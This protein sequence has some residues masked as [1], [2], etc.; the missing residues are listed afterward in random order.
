MGTQLGALTMIGKKMSLSVALLSLIPPQP[1][2]PQGLETVQ[3]LTTT[4]MKFLPMLPKWLLNRAMILRN[5]Q[6][7]RS[8]SPRTLDSSPSTAV[9]DTIRV[10]L[11]GSQPF[12]ALGRQCSVLETP[13]MSVQT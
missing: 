1:F 3:L 4:S 7:T 13:L 11:T 10:T 6:E 2:L 12:I 9:L 8:I 5:F